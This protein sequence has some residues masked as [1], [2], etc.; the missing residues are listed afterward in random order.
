MARVGCLRRSGGGL[1]YTSATTTSAKSQTRSTQPTGT[2]ISFVP[3][4]SSSRNIW[5]AWARTTSRHTTG[6]GDN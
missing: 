3:I 1:L 6:L 2:D 5:R 4:G